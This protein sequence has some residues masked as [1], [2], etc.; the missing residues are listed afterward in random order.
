MDMTLIILA[1]LIIGG[2]LVWD[3]AMQ[4]RHVGHIR[5]QWA[6]AD[7]T[8]AIPPIRT[9]CHGHYP[10]GPMT[11]RIVGALGVVDGAL[12]FSGQRA[13]TFDFATPLA[14]IRWIGQRTVVKRSWTKR[15][16]WPEL[17][18]HA[19]TAVGWRVYTF[20]E[21]PITTFATQLAAITGL[22]LH[23][24]GEG[25][26]DFGPF[27]AIYLVENAAGRWQ[28]LTDPGVDLDDL[29]PEWDGID[30][31]LY[32][33]PDRLLYD[34]ANPILLAQI[35]RV[36]VYAPRGTSRFNPYDRPLLRIEYMD[37]AGDRRA[38][39]FLTSTAGDWAGVL[40]NRLDVTVAH[41]AGRGAE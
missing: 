3:Q 8:V 19:E 31:T 35:R 37:A 14:A 10:P 18:I 39:G 36:D 12:T 38:A 28:R 6:G 4:Q 24:I 2:A 21:G 30:H 20:T 15:I 29:P 7:R 27:P 34:W 5:Q 40:E 11:E 41:H 17:I 23:E 13:D 32:L 9:I 33:T 16:E 22:G 26:E 25:F 1:I